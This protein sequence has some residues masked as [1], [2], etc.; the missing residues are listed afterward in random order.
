[1]GIEEKKTQFTPKYKGNLDLGC[2]MIGDGD[3][4]W[5]K[6]GQRLDVSGQVPYLYTQTVRGGTTDRVEGERLSV[7]VCVCERERD[8]DTERERDRETERDRERERETE[9]QS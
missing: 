8:R 6:N 3:L 7:V 1:M 2:T 4:V 9:R 5:Y